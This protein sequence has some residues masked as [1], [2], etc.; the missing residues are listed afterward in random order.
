[1]KTTVRIMIFGAMALALAMMATSAL[2]DPPDNYVPKFIQEPQIELWFGDVTTEVYYGHDEESMAYLQGTT[3][4]PD[5][6]VESYYN[7]MFM[8]DDFADKSDQPVAHV[9]WWGSYMGPTSGVN[10][11]VQQFLIS[12]ETDV[13]D[14]YPDDPSTYSYPGEV[15]SSEIVTLDSTGGI[16]AAGNFTERWIHSGGDPLYE[17]LFEYNAELAIPFPQEKDTVYWL[18]IVAL[19]DPDA[20]DQNEIIWGWHNRNY[21]IENTLASRPPSPPG[22][23]PGEHVQGIIFPPMPPVPVWH[24][25]DD[26][27]NGWVE[28]TV[29]DSI[30]PIPGEDPIQVYQDVFGETYYELGWD[31]P[32]DVT[33]LYS[34]DLAFALYAVPE[35]SSIVLIGMAAVCLLA[36]RRRKHL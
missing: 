20:P 5:G 7:G 15:I 29:K 8:A 25:Q 17:E 9:Q 36:I 30:D 12:F 10:Q 26:A 2:A 27:V 1:M 28:I 35:P 4:W 21:T 3:T 23:D 13:P 32:Y 33:E 16:P 24:F 22:V 31:M 6:T 11:Q 14:P 19:V 34:K 18:K